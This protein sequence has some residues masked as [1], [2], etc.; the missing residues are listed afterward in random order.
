MHR[1]NPQFTEALR[2]LPTRRLRRLTRS[3]LLPIAGLIAASVLALADDSVSPPWTGSDIGALAIAGGDAFNSKDG[4]WNAAGSGSDI[5]GASDQ[6]HLSYYRLTGDGTLV[7]KVN[8]IQNTDPWAKAGVMIRATLDANSPF[9]D[10]MVTSANGACFQYRTGFGAQCAHAGIAGA[11]PGWVKIQRTGSTIAGSFSTDGTNWT[12]VGSASISMGD[13][14]YIGLAVC[15]HNNGALNSAQFLSV[16]ATP[17]QAIATERF[18]DSLGVCTHW[19]YGDTVYGQN[20]PAVKQALIDLGIRHVRDGLFSNRPQDLAASGIKTTMVADLPNN[21]NGSIADV[22]SLVSQVQS[23]NG[24][25]P[26]SAIDSIEGPNEP[27]FFWSRFGKTY[28]G[29]GFPNGPVQYLKDL[30]TTA[31]GNS[32]TASLSIY[33][34]ALGQ[35]YGYGGNPLAN[36]SLAG[37][38]DNG[39]FHPYPGG[40]PFSFHYSYDTIDWYIGHGPQPSANIDEWPFAFDVYQPPYGIKPMVATETGYYTGSA[41]GSQSQ[42]AF[43]K[44]VP[45]LFLEYFRRGVRRTFDYELIDLFNDLGNDQDNRGLLYNNITPKPAFTALQS[46]IALIQE[47]GATFVPANAQLAYTVTPPAGYGSTQY[48]HHLLMQKSNGIY[49]LVI[50]HEIG[51]SCAYDSAGNA[52]TGADR[53]ITPPD[54][55]CS[56]SLPSTITGAILYSF[57]ANWK[58]QPSNLP[59]TSQAIQVNVQDR[60]QVIALSSGLVSG[61]TY[62][63]LHQGTSK[64]L[65]VFGGGSSDGTNVDQWQDNG[66]TNERWIVTSAGGGYYKLT[67]KGTSECL[68]VSGGSTSQGANVQQWGDNGTDAQRWLIQ[69]QSDGSY[70]LT[71]KG[72]NQCLDVSNNSSADGANVQQWT[73]NGSA[74]QRWLMIQAP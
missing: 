68:D 48:V 61:A 17:E 2:F 21:Y 42:T 9:A 57:D 24:T 60:V 12:A 11:A 10:M 25:V 29:S 30:Y 69:L 65:D 15:S 63:L 36:G 5:W 6:F 43:A 23:A 72:T 67:H 59:I 56:I 47:P 64:A 58:L 4:S 26:G 14:V 49:Y 16:T 33:G 73:D 1:T 38:V 53:D 71:H 52:L 51:D 62:K 70:K 41:N 35:T 54:M 66:I 46:L 27:D 37:S 45:R 34:I 22:Q 44:Y 13:P 8:S 32:A 74:A 7:A 40:N 50:Y 3:L 18:I 55:P 31:K 20:Y 39:N 19:G 28:N